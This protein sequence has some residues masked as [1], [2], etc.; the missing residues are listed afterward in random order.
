MTLSINPAKT[1]AH[2]YGSN[3]D[4]F[5]IIELMAVI[6]IIAILVTIIVTVQKS[7]VGKSK[8][9]ACQNHLKNLY[10]GL[11]MYLDDQVSAF[12]VD[13]P[14]GFD[15]D[16]LQKYTGSNRS[17]M[18]CPIVSDPELGYTP[19]SNLANAGKLRNGTNLGEVFGTN[20]AIYENVNGSSAIDPRH[21]NKALGITVTGA[22]LPDVTSADITYKTS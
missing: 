11:T 19:N 8:R 1:K 14:S 22:L 9:L 18:R 17:A 10:Q 7:A 3:R 20:V 12:E 13:F 2:K 6:A 16:F 5:T 4:A 21:N 15:D